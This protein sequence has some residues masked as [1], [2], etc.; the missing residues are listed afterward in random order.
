M[1]ES[2]HYINFILCLLILFSFYCT[3]QRHIHYKLHSCQYCVYLLKKF[4]ADL[5]YGR[6]RVKTF[7][8]LKKIFNLVSCLIAHHQIHPFIHR[9]QIYHAE[10]SNIFQYIHTQIVANRYHSSKQAKQTRLQ[11][12]ESKL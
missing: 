6:L 12:T 1:A 3:M 7:C 10:K 2:W 9:Q 4:S 5:D 8:H 11:G